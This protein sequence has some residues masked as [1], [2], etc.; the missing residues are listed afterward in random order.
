M[1]G[2][3]DSFSLNRQCES[4][5]CFCKVEERPFSRQVCQAFYIFL[6]EL[7]K[8]ETFLSLW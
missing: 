6:T 2:E 4:Q 1:A 3:I 5:V 7:A 8:P